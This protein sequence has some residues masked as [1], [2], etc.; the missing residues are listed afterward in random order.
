MINSRPVASLTA[1]VIMDLN[2]LK[3]YRYRNAKAA[4]TKERWWVGHYLPTRHRLLGWQ[5]PAVGAG[6]LTGALGGGINDTI[7]PAS[8]NVVNLPA[9][10]LSGYDPFTLGLL[11]QNLRATPE[12]RT[13]T[14]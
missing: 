12:G 3:S 4:T 9:E 1:R 14:L 10:A 2:V 7:D 11:Y 8:G 6:V 5:V 13:G